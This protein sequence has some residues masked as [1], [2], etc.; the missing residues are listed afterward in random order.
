M[1]AKILVVEDTL[2]TR[3]L[4][5]LHLKLEGFDVIVASDGREGFYM[6]TAEKPHLIVTDINM[7][8]M[9]GL[10]LIRQL[11]S[12]AEMKDVPIIALTAYGVEIR[13]DAIKAGANRAFD[14]PVH[15]EWLIEGINELLE[16]H[17]PG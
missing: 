3:D 5:H 11:R 9:D 1:A 10:Q 8:H 13:D 16:E 6:A 2:D 14:K 4:L 7:P 17:N 15:M 12:H